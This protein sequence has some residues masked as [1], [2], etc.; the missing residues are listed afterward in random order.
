MSLGANLPVLGTLQL[1]TSTPDRIVQFAAILGDL[2]HKKDVYVALRDF[3]P[4]VDRLFSNASQAAYL[5]RYRPDLIPPP[6]PN[7]TLPNDHALGTV[8][9]FHYYTDIRFRLDYVP[10]IRSL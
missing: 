9:E 4:Q 5:R 1:Y 7:G 10:R 2:E 3:G 8:F 6:A